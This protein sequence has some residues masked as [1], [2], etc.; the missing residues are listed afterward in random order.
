MKPM[1]LLF[2]IE[3][4]HVA[5]DEIFKSGKETKKRYYKVYSD[6]YGTEEGAEKR[7]QYLKQTKIAS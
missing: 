3:D 4:L 6:L 1:E 7:E 2:E 5:A